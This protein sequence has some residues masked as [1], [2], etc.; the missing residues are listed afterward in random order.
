MDLFSF[1]LIPTDPHTIHV[2]ALELIQMEL[3][4]SN[5]ELAHEN[6]SM[7][8]AADFLFCFQEKSQLNLNEL[9]IHVRRSF[10]S[11]KKQTI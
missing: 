8:S 10:L 4:D 5:I 1:H 3:N 7:T 9:T 2:S 11:V 6:A